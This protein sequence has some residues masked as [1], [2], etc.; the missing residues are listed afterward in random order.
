MVSEFRESPMFKHFLRFEEN[1][2][3]KSNLAYF[4][5]EGGNSRRN[6]AAVKPTTLTSGFALFETKYR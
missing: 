5:L 4:Y 1:S 3:E 6:F 2:S